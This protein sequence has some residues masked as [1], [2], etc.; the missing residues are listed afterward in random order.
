MPDTPTSRSSRSDS[1]GADAEPPASPFEIEFAFQDEK[2]RAIEPWLREQLVAALG[3]L[4]VVAARISIAVVDDAQMTDLHERYRR[5][6][7]TTDVLTFDFRFD[8]SDDDEPLILESEIIVC[9]DEARRQ[10]ADRGHDWKTEL[11][12]Y[13]VHGVLHLLEHDDQTPDEAARMHEMEDRLLSA[14]GIGE[15][16][17]SRKVLKDPGG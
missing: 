4:K 13:I 1:D 7:G 14:I 12:L 6:G 3:W 17:A 15:V 8:A 10:A 5:E 9:I 16:F 2:D 11:L